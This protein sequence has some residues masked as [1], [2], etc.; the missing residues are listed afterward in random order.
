MNRRMKT[1][2]NIPEMGLT[3][4]ERTFVAVRA[5]VPVTQMPPKSAEPILARPCPISSMEERWRRPDMPSAT[6][7]DRR[8]SIAPSNVNEMA[9]GKT[10][11]I[12]ANVTSGMLGKGNVRGIPPN[13]LP[14]VSTFRWSNA[15]AQDARTT[16]ISNPG[17]VGRKRRRIRIMAIVAVAIA[18][19][20]GFAVVA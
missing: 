12:F 11:I 15:A 4:P 17:H 10:A 7:A 9:S 5:I 19:A 1:E 8:D 2:C 18:T 13:R 14:I 16:A 3:A 6:T 20:A